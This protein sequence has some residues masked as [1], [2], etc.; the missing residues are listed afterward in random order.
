M[1]PLSRDPQAQV[2]QGRSEGVERPEELALLQ[3]LGCD[4]AQGYLIARPMPLVA[5]EEWAG[6]VHPASALTQPA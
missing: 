2:A 5:A 3:S 4:R 6:S 1:S